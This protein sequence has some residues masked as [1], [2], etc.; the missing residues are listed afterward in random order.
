MEF[1]SF[2]TR[3]V[4]MT[5]KTLGRL[6]GR[7]GRVRWFTA[8]TTVGLLIMT[9]AVIGDVILSYSMTGSVGPGG[10]SPFTWASDTN[11]PAAS[12]LA[13]VGGETCQTG[14][15]FGTNCYTMSATIYGISSVATNMINVY[16][17]KSTGLTDAWTLS[18]SASGG[19]ALTGGCAYVIISNTPI[20]KAT[21]T[22]GSWSG[23]ACVAPIVGALGA[24][25][26]ACTAA[27]PA[28][29]V[30]YN[31]ANAAVVSGSVPACSVPAS[32]AGATYELSY[33]IYA[34]AGAATVA[35]S[36]ITIAA[37]D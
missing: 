6:F 22:P 13:L 7:K 17:F 28:G 24:T 19:A 20:V 21:Y 9:G 29:Y 8:I 12:N 14:G 15:T 37:T 31:L 5:G 35:G 30:M 16:S 3:G 36:T 4:K 11:Y 34:P 18:L 27:T 2:H 32:T 33:F 1:H 26:A 23:S 25:N 10:N